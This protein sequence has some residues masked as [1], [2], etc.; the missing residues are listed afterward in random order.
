MGTI[1]A[2]PVPSTPLTIPELGLRKREAA[3]QC[4]LACAREAG[5]I[6]E[7]DA[8]LDALLL[9]ERLG[10]TAIGKGV[11]V[12]NVRSLGIHEPRVVF[13]RSARGIPWEARDAQPVHLVFLVLSPAETSLETHLDT[14]TRMV[15][16]TRLARHRSRLLE[17]NGAAA[18]AALLQPVIP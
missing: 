6:R 10:T 8:V 13:A 1:L 11:A 18:L 12:P 4:M 7:A 15:A 16:A 3:L 2:P 5:A 14:V 9:R 17:A